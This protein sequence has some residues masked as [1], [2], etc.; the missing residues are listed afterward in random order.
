MLNFI[1]YPIS[2]VLWFWHKAL[3]F[4]LAPDSGVTWA[5]A[6]ILLV[7]TLRVLLLKPT[8]N[9]MRSARK[10]QELQ[11]KLQALQAKYGKDQRQELGL[12]MQKLRK[13]AG[14][15]P[16]AS[17]LPIVVQMPI[18]LGLFHVLRSFNRTGTH[19]GE[20]GMSVQETRN[21]PNYVFGVDEVQSFL[22]ARLFGA[23]LSG[24][25]GMSQD[26]YPAFSPEGILSDFTRG[27][28]I[29]VVVPL[30][31]ISAVMMHFSARM[32]L[33]RS[34]RKRA[35][36]PKKAQSAQAQQMASQMETMQKLM[37]WVMPVMYLSGGFLWQVG[38]AVYM[39]TNNAW[40]LVQ[41][42][43]VFRKMDREEEEER[44][45]KLEAKRTTAPKPGVK[46]ANPKKGRGAAKASGTSDASAGAG[47]STPAGS[48]AA[49]S[50][51]AGGSSAVSA[52]GD[53]DALS[54]GSATAAG[55]TASADDGADA[56]P[57]T[58]PRPGVKPANSNRKGGRK[59]GKKKR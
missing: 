39:F 3:S 6:I 21:T 4:V 17:C 15:N 33:D 51:P 34:A 23:P 13:E 16:L 57:S 35:Q 10:M 32:S 46:P 54:D 12:E 44:Q 45:A 28:I 26:A 59:R 25:I 11:P 27:N 48:T 38:L 58:A 43:L 7:V 36:Q 9:Q 19:M 55:A 24:S 52:Q 31:V 20:I 42:I 47:T 5:L 18:F 53:D 8:I 1:Y 29:A 50:T 22:D 30:M 37:L 40:T 49:G 2:A 14:V 41:N 56:S